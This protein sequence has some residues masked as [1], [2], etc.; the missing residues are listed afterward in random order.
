MTICQTIPHIFDLASHYE[1]G[2]HR[3]V[4]TQALS[5]IDSFNRNKARL[6]PPPATTTR[7][8][9][10]VRFAIIA[11]VNA[12]IAIRASSTED[13]V[14]R[15]QRQV[16]QVKIKMGMQMDDRTFQASLL[17][18]QVRHLSPFVISSLESS[19]R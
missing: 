15:G 18:T 16:E 6:E 14:R 12:F 8:R 3:M 4:G 19:C 10:G 7:P 17:E 9:L 11:P 5:A 2:E 13:A 1:C